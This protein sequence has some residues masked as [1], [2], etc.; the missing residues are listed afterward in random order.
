M[1]TIE[2]IKSEIPWFFPVFVFIVGACIGSF[3]NVCIYRLP[4]GKSIVHPPSQSATGRR[5]SWWEN[6]P[7][8]AWFYLGGKDRVTKE[9]YS[10][11]Y[12]LV[13]M[14]T[15]GL[16]LLC[17]FRLEPVTA[18]IGMLFMVILIV[19]TFIDLDHMILP[20]TFTVGG[21][22]AGFFIS[23]WLPVLHLGD[24]GNQYMSANLMSGIHALV[25]ILVGAGLVYWIKELAEIIL[26]KPAMG[27]GDIKFLGCIGAFCGWEGAVFA[28][29]GGAMI[30]SVILLP[31]ILVMKLLNSR[32]KSEDEAVNAIGLEVP[33]GPM[34]AVGGGVYFLWLQEPVDGYFRMVEAIIIG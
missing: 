29:F 9:P 31:V 27:E 20:D 25:G 2:F 4:E 33:F 5:L 22:I 28:L 12:P 1:E 7:I 26:K 24:T 16:F 19:S 17:W 11:R 6:V 21:M 10:F 32:K 8:L 15:A 34:L 18:L 14:L 30:G 13:E 3:L 23:I